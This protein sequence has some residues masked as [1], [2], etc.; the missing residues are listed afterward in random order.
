MSHEIAPEVRHSL[1]V[2]M[3]ADGSAVKTVYSGGF[4][5]GVG[6]VV[7]EVQNESLVDIARERGM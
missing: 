7:I 1:T 3:D 2:H 4:R 6:A 5:I